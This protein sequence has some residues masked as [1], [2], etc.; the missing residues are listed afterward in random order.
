MTLVGQI[1]VELKTQMEASK[2]F[3]FSDRRKTPPSKQFKPHMKNVALKNNPIIVLSPE[4]QVFEL[5][6][7]YAEENAPQYHILEDSKVIKNSNFGTEQ[8]LG[9]QRKVSD[10]RKRDYGK[11]TYLKGGNIVKIGQEYRTAFKSRSNIWGVNTTLALKRFNARNEKRNYRYNIHFGY[12][13]RIL[14]EITPLI[15]QQFNARLVV[16]DSGSLGDLD[17][18]EIVENGESNS[19]IGI[20][21]IYEDEYEA[22][23][24]I[25]V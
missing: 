19:N 3:P 22:L 16:R 7:E 20:D 2:L 6:N 24:T 18:L 11:V 9:S 13:E 12:I 4:I 23:Y 8:S 1:A 17:G 10:V 5:G 21:D 14:E 15:A 25:K